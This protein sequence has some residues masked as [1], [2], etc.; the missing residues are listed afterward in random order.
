MLPEIRGKRWSVFVLRRQSLLAEVATGGDPW[1][2]R[3]KAAK[4]KPGDRT[5]EWFVEDYIENVAKPAI[6][7]WAQAEGALRRAWLPAI[8]NVPI[9]DVAR[10]D[11]YAVLKA[12][13]ADGRVGAAETAR[14][15]VSRIFNYALDQGYIQMSP[16]QRLRVKAIENHRSRARALD[17]DEVAAI[18]IGIGRLQQPWRV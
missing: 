18:W 11:L 8:G 12:I 10:T 7:T 13:V 14:K 16:A 9:R 2:E 17:S 6:K 5:F 1:A 4:L 3:R 15:H